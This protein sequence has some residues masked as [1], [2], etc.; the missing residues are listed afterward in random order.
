MEL[1]LDDP[2]SEPAQTTSAGKAKTKARTWAQVLRGTH[3]WT[4]MGCNLREPKTEIDHQTRTSPR[5]NRN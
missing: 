3:L 1:G 5:S 4:H 2:P